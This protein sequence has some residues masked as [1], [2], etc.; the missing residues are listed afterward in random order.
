MTAITRDSGDYGD[1]GE[2]IKLAFPE[3]SRPDVTLDADFI[4]NDGD[5]MQVI[6]QHIPL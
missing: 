6:R 1:S 4:D 5:L 2:H 3:C